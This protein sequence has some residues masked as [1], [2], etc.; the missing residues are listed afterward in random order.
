MADPMNTLSNSCLLDDLGVLR[1]GGTDVRKF[2]QGQL[3]NDIEQLNPGAVLRAGLHNPQG[4]TLAILCIGLAAEGDLLALMPRDLI[5]NISTLLKRYVLRSK[6]TIQDAT[7]SYRIVGVLSAQAPERVAGL[8]YRY[9]LPGDERFLVLQD[10]SRPTDS[11]ATVRREQWHALDVAAGL[12]QVTAA[13]SGQFVAQMLNLD[14]ID[15]ISFSKGCYTGQEIIA[16][17]HYRGRVKRR[18]Q[19]FLSEAPLS[20]GPGDSARLGD[21]RHFRVVTAATRED[22]RSE[23]LAVAHV[24]GA[25]QESEEGP[26]PGSGPGTG[27]GHEPV[28]AATALALP[29]ALP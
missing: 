5:V 24:P 6:V 1:L 13:T 15:A 25:R 19:R 18:M 2:L 3:S 17:A 12:P 7:D 11:P 14:C 29:Y 27:L 26:A 8:R 9:G 23:F 16:R 20:L 21:G 4:R 10:S 22:G 28:V